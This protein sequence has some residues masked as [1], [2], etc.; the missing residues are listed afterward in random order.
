[1]ANFVCASRGNFGVHDDI[2]YKRW[3]AAA[4]TGFDYDDGNGQTRRCSDSGCHEPGGTPAFDSPGS[5]TNSTLFLDFFQPFQ[6]ALFLFPTDLSPLDPR[7][8][9]NAANANDF[10]TP[11]GF[12]VLRYTETPHDLGGGGPILDI[13]N[14]FDNDAN[15]IL[16]ANLVTHFL[17]G[18]APDGN[19]GAVTDF[20]VSTGV[21]NLAQITD[22]GP[23][24]LESAIK[25]VHFEDPAATGDP[26]NVRGQ[27]WIDFFSINADGS[28][29]QN[30]DLIQYFQAPVTGGQINN[31]NGD[32]TY[33]FAYAYNLNQAR[34]FFS[35]IVL[36]SNQPYILFVNG[37]QVII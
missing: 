26:N 37:Q 31:R 8:N 27:P 6:S 30:V 11:E 28:P 17:P 22:E 34:N 23:I 25:P 32:T 12:N 5:F 36:N 19:N 35:T 33:L 1:V 7:A 14:N 3:I 18:L 21:F 16:A 2:Y 29:K 24:T 9:G 15:Q 4:T 13:K 10:T 20:L